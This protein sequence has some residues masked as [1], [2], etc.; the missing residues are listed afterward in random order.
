MGA[1]VV[2][3]KLALV[4]FFLKINL[5]RSFHFIHGL[6]EFADGFAEHA[7]DLLHLLR[8]EHNQTDCGEQKNFSEAQTE[9]SENLP[10]ESVFALGPIVRDPR[11]NW[12]ALL[13]DLPFGGF[14]AGLKIDFVET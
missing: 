5:D 14:T 11:R 12:Q 3:A 9:Q 7:C 6:F 10:V 1:G 4:L 13:F 8:T 2:A